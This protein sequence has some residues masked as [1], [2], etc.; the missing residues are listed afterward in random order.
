M[1]LCDCGSEVWSAKAKY[2]LLCKKSRKAAGRDKWRKENQ[3]TWLSYNR[4]Y[5]KRWRAENAEKLPVYKAKWEAKNP[6]RAKAIRRQASRR[7]KLANRERIAERARSNPRRAIQYRKSWLEKNPTYFSD[8]AKANRP[9]KNLA[10]QRRRARLR[11]SCS[12]GVSLD[13]W[14]HLCAIH[15]DRCAYCDEIKPLTIDHVVPIS[16]GG[17]DEAGNVVPACK[18]CNSSKGN[19]LLSEWRGR[20]QAAA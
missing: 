20:L 14:L 4:Q 16:R 5:Y 8:W 6:D 15:D 3:E 17:R 12:P 10:N 18:P 7:W 13:T 2:C 9:K 19:R 1:R 11:D